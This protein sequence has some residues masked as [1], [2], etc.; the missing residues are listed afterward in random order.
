MILFEG[1][2]ESTFLQSFSCRHADAQT[3]S[4]PGASGHTDHMWSS[5]SLLVY[6]IRQHAGQIFCV[7]LHSLYRVDASMFLVVEGSFG[8]FTN[9]A[10]VT[11]LIVCPE[12]HESYAGIVCRCLYTP[13]IH[14]IRI[15]RC[16][17]AG[18]EIW[19]PTHRPDSQSQQGV[20]P[21]HLKPKAKGAFALKSR[22]ILYQQ[23]NLLTKYGKETHVPDGERFDEWRSGLWYVQSAILHADGPREIWRLLNGISL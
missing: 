18:N 11:L 12:L 21:R 15:R 5:S 20:R 23:G 10:H 3:P 4:H 19:S 16:S 22:K 9:A 14:E 7:R 8:D 1:V 13:N 17:T 2:G 6:K